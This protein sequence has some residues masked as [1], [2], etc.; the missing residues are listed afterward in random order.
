MK[1]KTQIS[2]AL[3][4]VMAIAMVSLNFTSK[5]DVDGFVY[6]KPDHQTIGVLS[7]SPDGTLFFADSKSAAIYGVRLSDDKADASKQAMNIGDID[8][9]IADMMGVT[10]R[11]I[12]INDMATNPVTNSVYLSV[13]RGLGNDTQYAL[14][15]VS[16]EGESKIGKIDLVDLNKVSYTKY[17]LTDAPSDADKDR[18][19]NS[20]RTSSITDIAF[21][22]N[23]LFVSGLSNEEFASTFR[24]VPFP[25]KG[26][27]VGSKVEIFHAAHGRYETNA[28]IRTFMPMEMN[29]QSYIVAAYTCTPLVTFPLSD[30]KDGEHIMGK[31]AAELGSNN[32]PV[33]IVAFERGGKQHIILSNSNRSAMRF[34]P[35]DIIKQKTLKDPISES[36]VSGGAP[37]VQLPLVQ[38][39]QLDDLNDDNL[40]IIE[41]NT[42]GGLN[43]R[44]ISKQWISGTR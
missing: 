2:I 42:T 7:F 35:A 12:R 3:V 8:S 25:F 9:K 6:G 21:H 34:D 44:S 13:T 23:E 11:E 30:V 40:A 22:D 38:V 41:R 19:G 24:R 1:K 37:Y 32:R 29:G 10:P 27:Q 20:L 17:T 15:K 36:F 18:R 5:Y 28:P 4:A 16:R 14:L 43:L 33:D 39:L 31:T 26:K